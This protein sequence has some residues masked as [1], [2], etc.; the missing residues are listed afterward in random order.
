MST[1]V[2]VEHDNHR[3]QSATRNT[4]AAA[5]SFDSNPICLVVG[6]QCKDVAEQVA[7]IAGVHAVWWVDKPC[8]SS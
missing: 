5:L 2:L 8:Y 6:H 4:I 7:C 1:L 3:M